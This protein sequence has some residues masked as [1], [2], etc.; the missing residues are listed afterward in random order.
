MYGM[1]SEQHNPGCFGLMGDIAKVQRLYIRKG[2]KGKQRFVQWGLTC[3]DCGAVVQEEFLPEPK[4]PEQIKDM[5]ERVNWFNKP[6][7][8][9][10][11]ALNGLI[12]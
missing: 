4:T 10:I 5:E 8:D 6:T 2:P 1:K 11:E 9:K 3:L 7:A 12:K